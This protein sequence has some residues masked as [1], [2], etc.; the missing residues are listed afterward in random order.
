[1][2]HT[3]S[4]LRAPEAFVDDIFVQTDRLEDLRAFV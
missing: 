1:M 3:D 2:E 4:G